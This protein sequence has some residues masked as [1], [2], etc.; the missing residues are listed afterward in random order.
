MSDATQWPLSVR[1]RGLKAS[2]TRRSRKGKDEEKN[3]TKVKQIRRSSREDIGSRNPNFLS[4]ATR[5]RQHQ[6]AQINIFHASHR[7]KITRVNNLKS[8]SHLLSAS[9]VHLSKILPIKFPIPSMVCKAFFFFFSWSCVALALTGPSETVCGID[10]SFSG[11]ETRGGDCSLFKQHFV[12]NERKARKG[13]SWRTDLERNETSIHERLECNSQADCRER[14]FGL[15]ATQTNNLCLMSMNRPTHK[16]H[17]SPVFWSR[18]PSKLQQQQQLKSVF[19][20][21]PHPVLPGVESVMP[22]LW[23]APCFVINAE[24]SANAHIVNTNTLWFIL[25]H[26]CGRHAV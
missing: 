1:V 8:R 25:S 3:S 11:F 7:S 18:S 6:N 2:R 16:Q 13:R 10:I 17:S 20:L 4:E 22:A 23:S 5:N 24:K 21:F 19:V 12:Q 26:N 14:K 9:S 15:E